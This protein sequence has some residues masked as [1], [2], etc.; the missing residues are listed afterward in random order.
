MAKSATATATAV[1]EIVV[2]S[3][4]AGGSAGTAGSKGGT[5]TGTGTGPKNTPEA[6]VKVSIQSWA[7]AE[8]E[9]ERMT[10]TAIWRVIAACWNAKQKGDKEDWIKKY[11]VSGVEDNFGPGSSDAN[12]RGAHISKILK[13]A[14]NAKAEDFER[15]KKSGTGFYKAYEEFST[16]QKNPAKSTSDLAASIRAQNT[17][18][19]V[20]P[21]L[22]TEERMEQ[23][24]KEFAD[25]D[26]MAKAE[27][28]DKSIKLAKQSDE[29]KKA[30]DKEAE[31]PTASWA[32]RIDNRKSLWTSL[33]RELCQSQA[34]TVD[35]VVEVFEIL[36]PISV[37]KVRGVV[38]KLMQEPEFAKLFVTFYRDN[39]QFFDDDGEGDGKE[40]IDPGVEGE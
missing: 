36:H 16:K 33:V 39:P 21:T 35:M 12:K 28:K 20:D 15:W 18:G 37:V 30:R 10:G 17:P 38:D 22:G 7:K 31:D 11:L 2:K 8:A 32:T 1:K 23:Q 40:F 9:A 5:G 25:P 19:Y 6:Q 27:A 26:A 13:I 14:F 4:N 34:M 29:A 3:P 24:N